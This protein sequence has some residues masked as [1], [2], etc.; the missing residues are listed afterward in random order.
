MIRYIN[1]HNFQCHENKRVTL[2]PGITTLTGTS[3]SGKSAVI[4]AI[5]WVRTNRPRGTAFIR[6]GEE[7]CFAEINTSNG[8]VVRIRDKTK[9][10]YKV[11]GELLQA[12]GV[13]VPDGVFD[14]LRLSD[15]NVQNQF[16]PPFLLTKSP[17]EIGKAINEFADLSE[18][19]E[20]LFKLNRK[21]ARTKQEIARLEQE[22]KKLSES[23]KIFKDLALLEGKVDSAYSERKEL[24]KERIR[25]ADILTV[26]DAIEYSTDTLSGLR[27]IDS[28]STS[29]CSTEQTINEW[30]KDLAKV[31]AL[32]SIVNSIRKWQPYSEVELPIEKYG[33]LKQKTSELDKECRELF[34]LFTL[35]DNIELYE[36][37]LNQLK[38]ELEQIPTDLV[39]PTCGQ[40]VKVT[41]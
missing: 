31:D 23:L 20:T 24:D 1:L 8:N 28:I 27:S 3:D 6:N 7:T 5:E 34:H 19:D 41:K 32:K 35:V 29:V 15:L 13:S 9:N 26:L 10:G 25:L 16:D 30:S 18:A 40:V 33:L 14:T 22:Q 11:N 4:R 17:G 39:C 2:E 12:V 36:K 38:E 37:Q 21:V